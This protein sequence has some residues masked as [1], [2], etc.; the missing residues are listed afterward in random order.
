M[1]LVVFTASLAVYANAVMDRLDPN[2][3]VPYRL[4]RDS[5]TNY[6]GTYIKD[7]GRMGRDL[8]AP[9]LLSS[10]SSF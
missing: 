1:Q 6:K 10:A 2:G 4:F 8:K 5:C 3:Y 9:H 7:M